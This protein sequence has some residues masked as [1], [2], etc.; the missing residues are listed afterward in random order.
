MSKFELSKE[1]QDKINAFLESDAAFKAV[2]NTFAEKYQTELDYLENLRESRNAK[3]D[4]ARRALRAEGAEADITKVKSFRAGPF[5]VKKPWSDFYQPEKFASRLRDTGLYDK[6][7]SSKIIKE[8]VEIEKPDV[9]KQFLTTIGALE[10]FED[11]EDGIE[12]ATRIEG[13]KP[14]APFATEVKETKKEEK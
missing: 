8:S 10:L 5:T 9:V 2:W 13:P 4:E 3:L 12:L 7:L 14:I 6:A 11:C 1:A